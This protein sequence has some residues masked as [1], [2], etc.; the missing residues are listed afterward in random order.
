MSHAW[1]PTLQGG[2][3]PAGLASED[4]HV[5]DF[6]DFDK[7][8]WHRWEFDHSWCKPAAPER[9]RKLPKKRSIGGPNIAETLDASSCPPGWSSRARALARGTPTPWRWWQ[10]A[11]WWPW[12]AMMGSRRWVMP[13]RLTPRTSRTSGGR[14]PMPARLPLL[15]EHDVLRPDFP[16]ICVNKHL[17]IRQAQ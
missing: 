2:I 1:L 8:R 14:S 3:G 5:L 6:T 7:P 4:L 10:I 16:P 13:G 11:S 9:C 17:T 15:G 12:E